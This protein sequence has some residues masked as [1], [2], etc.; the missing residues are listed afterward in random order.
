[1]V[2]STNLGFPRIGRRRELK[3]ALESHWQGPTSAQELLETAAALQR[4]NIERQRDLGIDI[5]PTGDFSLYD[6]VLDTTAMVGAVPARYLWS[7]QGE[8]DLQTY[9]AM[10]RGAQG[11]GR[12]VVAMEMTKWFDTNYHYIVPEFLPGQHFNLSSHK[13]LDDLAL[14]KGLGVD[15]KPVLLGPLSYLLLGKAKEPGLVPWRDLLDPVLEVYREVIAALAAAGAAWI[16]MDEPCLVQDRTP[17]ELEALGR[18]Y[19]ALASSRGKANLAVHTYFGD[20]GAAFPALLALPVQAIGLDFVRG[21]D[22]LQL[23]R[24]HGLPADKTL[25]AGVVDGRNIWITDLE[26]RLQ[27]CES[28]AGITGP[29][30]LMLAPSCSLLHVPIDL[31]QESHLRKTDPQLVSWMAFAEQKLGEVV[32]LTRALN[33]GREAVRTALE[34]NAAAIAHRQNSDRTH[35]PAVEQRLRDLTPASFRRDRPFAERRRLQGERLPLPLLP[36]TTIGSFPQTEAVRRL[37]ARWRKGEL[38]D[39]QY[40]TE[41]RTEIERTIRLQEDLGLDVLVHGEFERND[42][43]EYFGEQLAGFSFTEHGWVQSYGSRYVKPPILYG[44]VSR[45]HPMTVR[46]TQYAQ[47]LTKKP[48]KGMLTGPVTILQWSFV[49]DDQERSK[50]C[51][52]IALAIADEVADLERAGIHAIQID[53]PALR[54]GLPLRRADW[55]GYLRWAVDAFRLAASVAKPETQ[56][57]THMCYSEFNDIMEAISALDADVI[58][59]ENSRSDQELLRA[60]EEHRYDKAIGP[61]VYDIHSPRVPAIEEIAARLRLAL[62]VLEPWQVWVNPDCGLKTRGWEETVPA[63][64]HMVAAAGQVRKG[65]DG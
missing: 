16:Q 17:E 5:I 50:T 28:L 2:R 11:G 29:D 33:V 55:S 45:P 14:G 40:E 6:Q 8:V 18:A 15:A 53:E 7:G 31:S 22:N 25:V 57:H 10:A 62:E 36:T 32:T 12:D 1:M 61:G 38:T 63:L 43:V 65:L 58:S 27:L 42:M 60:F 30:R 48:V 19:A 41:V 47:S 23:L 39:L 64:R 9:F 51:H 20:P 44:T 37:R 13:P 35:A 21:P 34:V 46:W 49:R 56:I 26:Q 4:Q 59:I 3:R 54:E 52:E 24:H